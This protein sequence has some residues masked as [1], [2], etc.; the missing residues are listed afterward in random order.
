MIGLTFVDRYV[1]QGDHFYKSTRENRW[2]MSAEKNLLLKNIKLPVFNKG[3]PCKLGKI[4]FS[5][6]QC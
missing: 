5:D 2:I 1:I 4:Y 6:N 3:F